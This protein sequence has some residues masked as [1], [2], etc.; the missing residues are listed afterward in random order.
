[1]FS[2]SMH[3]F[4]FCENSVFF[5]M[6]K[7]VSIVTQVLLSITSRFRYSIDQNMK[8]DI[9]NVVMCF[10]FAPDYRIVH[11]V[12]KGSS[13]IEIKSVDGRRFYSPYLIRYVKIQSPREFM[14][15]VDKFFWKIGDFVFILQLEEKFKSKLESFVLND[16]S[17]HYYDDMVLF[18]CSL[19]DFLMD[20][21]EL[22]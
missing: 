9:T 1:M 12:G 8:H 2:L 19:L 16:I 3:D 11:K 21:V 20:K 15:D 13:T 17:H 14:E 18:H 7:V 22:F 10:S 4:I 6:S 5:F